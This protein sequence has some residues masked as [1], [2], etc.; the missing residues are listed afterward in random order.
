MVSIFE[1]LLDPIPVIT[2]WSLC[3]DSPLWKRFFLNP[4]FDSLI[5]QGLFMCLYFFISN[6]ILIDDR[7]L[8][9]SIFFGISLPILWLYFGLTLLHRL[10]SLLIFFWRLLSLFFAFVQKPWILN[11][12]LGF[13]LHVVKL[14]VDLF[15]VLI[16]V[17]FNTLVNTPIDEKVNPLP[18][19]WW[20][21]WEILNVSVFS[22]IVVWHFYAIPE[23][24]R[25]SDRFFDE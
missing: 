25:I 11:Q 8:P 12:F 20:Q 16:H 22:C 5:L 7:R 21:I 3:Y 4:I 24:H 18:Q 10:L 1:T 13:F 17:L 15:F 14:P 2:N 23:G 19:I 6:G 9:N